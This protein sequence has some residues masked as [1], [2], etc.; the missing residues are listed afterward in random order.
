MFCKALVGHK[1]LATEDTEIAEMQ[2][3]LDQY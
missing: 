1:T 2:I 3:P